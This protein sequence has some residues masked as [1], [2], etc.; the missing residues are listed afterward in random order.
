MTTPHTPTISVIVPV[1][2]AALSLHRCVDS[3]LAQS[4][5]DW[6]LLLIDDGS[7]DGSSVICDRYAQDDGRIRVIHKANEGVAATRRRGIDEARGK[8]SL[9]V[10]SDDWAEPT[11]L[12]ELYATAESQEADMVIC[13][14]YYDYNGRK[15]VKH[16]SQEPSGPGCESVLMDLLKGGRLRPYCWN[17]LVRHECYR[18][19]G[20]IIPSDISHGE[21]FL[22][23]L[24][25]LRHPEMRVAYLPKAF[26]HYVH[27]EHSNLL[28][29]TYSE[30]DFEREVRLRGYCLQLMEGHDLYSLVEERNTYLIVRRAFNGGIFS[31]KEFKRRTWQFKDIIKNNRDLAWH[32]RYRLYLACG[33]A[34]RL[35]YG[36]RT[37]GNMVR[38]ATQRHK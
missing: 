19:Y 25:L 27:S 16:I 30:E 37:L 28:T 31:S 7:V 10:D 22:I 4:F 12:E 17:K 33:G 38:R 3:I 23:C 14:F 9:Q 1:Y 24:S 36:Y 26:Y 15:P 5:T 34:Y 13:D 21:D 2:N 8:Y 35:M 6:E 11:M 18:K 29:R 32:K 20:V